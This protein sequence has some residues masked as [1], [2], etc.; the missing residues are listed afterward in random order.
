[1]LWA[2]ASVTIQFEITGD[3][4]EPDFGYKNEQVLSGS[5]RRLQQSNYLLKQM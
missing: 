2:K 4:K 1:M 3:K 5:E